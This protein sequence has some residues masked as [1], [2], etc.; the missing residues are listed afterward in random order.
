MD[1]AEV[2]A[3]LAAV[4]QQQALLAEVTDKLL[5]TLGQ[6]PRK[7]VKVEVVDLTDDTPMKS[8]PPPQRA[9]TT[10]KTRRAGV[11]EDAPPQGPVAKLVAKKKAAMPI[12]ESFGAVEGAIET[13]DGSQ[14]D[15]FTVE[16]VGDW[17]VARLLKSI[18]DGDA[19]RT[20]IAEQ[21]CPAPFLYYVFGGMN[22]YAHH[23]IT[24]VYVCSVAAMLSSY[25]FDVVGVVCSWLF[26]GTLENHCLGI[27]VASRKAQK[28]QVPANF[29]K[30]CSLNRFGAGRRAMAWQQSVNGALLRSVS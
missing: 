10:A 8:E 23:L 2:V 3:Q 16:G 5:A 15:F 11:R 29:A 26:C 13:K 18:E 19:I 14:I 24:I 9:P 17:S 21:G 28:S 1:Q 30:I 22:P 12:H 6:T 20:V 27:G 4:M 25:V 7:N